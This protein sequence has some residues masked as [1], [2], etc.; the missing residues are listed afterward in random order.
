MFYIMKRKGAL[1]P[2]EN[3]NKKKLNSKSQKTLDCFG[4]N[5]P[6]VNHEDNFPEMSSLFFNKLKII[7]WNVN[8]IRAVIKRNELQELIKKESPDILCL[9]ETKIDEANLRAERI[10]SLFSK[11]YL[12]YWNASKERKGYSGVALF[13]K[14]KPISVTYDINIPEHDK[15]GRVITAEYPL[16][17]LICVYVPNSGKERLRYRTE[18]WDIDFQSYI[19]TLVDKKKHVIV[20]GD[21][22][23]CHTDNDMYDVQE[24]TNVIPGCFT[25]ER[26]NMT[27][28]LNDGY[29]DSFRYMKGY[30]A[31]E[32]SQY[33]S[34][35]YMKN[36]KGLRLDYFI[37]NG[38]AKEHIRRSDILTQYGGSDHLP[39]VLEIGLEKDI[40]TNEVKN[41]VQDND[42]STEESKNSQE[43]K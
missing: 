32:F 20:A 6:K 14:Y 11:T 43:S 1:I 25:E 28:W 33:Q 24:L 5:I 21:L 27:K 15:E 38:S 16:F 39:I 29:V 8:G 31:I 40:K 9:N 34:L 13:S 37:L 7:S 36:K 26:D 12:T 22:N 23:V 2:P 35:Y 41:P 4:I 19:K 17:Y 18:K 3:I 10:E 42:K 30:D